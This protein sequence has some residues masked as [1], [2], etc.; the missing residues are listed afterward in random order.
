MN[1]EKAAMGELVTKTAA[2]VIAAPIEEDPPFDPT[3]PA[4]EIIREDIKHIPAALTHA[5]SVCLKVLQGT[6]LGGGARLAH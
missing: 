1:A 2:P 5:P 6:Y 3:R 4:W